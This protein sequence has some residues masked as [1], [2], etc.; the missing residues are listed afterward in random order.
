[1]QNFTVLQPVCFLKQSIIATLC[2]LLLFGSSI[3]LNAQVYSANFNSNIQSWV[4]GSSNSWSRVSTGGVSNSGCLT[5]TIVCEQ[6]QQ[7]G[8]CINE[9]NYFIATP[10]VSLTGGNTY[11]ISIKCSVATASTRKLVLGVNTSQ[12]RS[13]ATTLQNFGYVSTGGYTAFTVNYTPTSSGSPYFVLWGEKNLTQTVGLWLD[14][15]AVTLVN[16]AP[17]VSLTNPDN[18]SVYVEGDSPFLF[19]ASVSDAENN[20]SK[21]EFFSNGTKVGERTSTPL[22]I[23]Y[24]PTVGGTYSLTAKATDSYGASTTSAARSI[25]FRTRPLI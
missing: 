17:T 4:N 21:V 25:S 16:S 20:L 7:Q 8:S 10:S 22:S 18:N 9:N 15:F 12:A 11:Q 14:D 23:T 13:G 2:F 6:G 24:I 5:S 3:R 1:M 19:K